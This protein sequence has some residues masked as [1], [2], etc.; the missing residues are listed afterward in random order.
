MSESPVEPQPNVDNV[1]LNCSNN[2]DMIC[3]CHIVTTAVLNVLIAI[4]LYFSLPF[5]VVVTKRQYCCM[6]THINTSKLM[7]H[8]M[9]ISRSVTGTPSPDLRHTRKTV[10]LSRFKWL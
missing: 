8:S 7:A 1:Y 3:S 4:I 2:A 6:S 5:L 10:L 9:D